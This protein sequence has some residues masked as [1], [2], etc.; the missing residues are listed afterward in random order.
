MGE[1]G[2]CYRTKDAKDIHWLDQYKELITIFIQVNQLQNCIFEIVEV[3]AHKKG[4]RYIKKLL[5]IL[6]IMLKK[7]K[8]ALLHTKIFISE[9]I[10]WS[11][12]FLLRSPHGKNSGSGS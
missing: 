5:L 11:G 10:Q 1:G 8:K 2:N 9:I 7:W 3:I 6:L 4:N 12:I